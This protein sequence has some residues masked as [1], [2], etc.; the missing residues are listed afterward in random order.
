MEFEIKLLDKK[1]EAAD[2]KTFFFTRPKGFSYIAG[3]YVYLTLPDLLRPDERGDT[4]H[5]TLSSSPTE[6]DLAITVR[7]RAESG[8]KDTLDGYPVGTAISMCGPNGFFTLDPSASSGQAATPQV[9][10]AGGIGITPYRSIIRYVA[11]KNLSVPIHLIYSNSIPEKII[12]KNELDK[13]TKEH[14]NI[15]VTYAITRPEESRTKWSGPTGRIDANF[16]K[17]HSLSTN[18]YPLTPTF[19][20][21]GPPAMVGAMEEVLYNMGIPNS[22][23]K[24]E[25]FT[26]Y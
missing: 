19:W 18:H 25:K 3:Q 6:T 22:K 2:T 24:V 23:V 15:Q 14:G 10:I 12:F 4:R 13:I 21:C 16:L 1:E 11:D 5:F 20:L 9:M 17:K 7:M 26:G 8:Y